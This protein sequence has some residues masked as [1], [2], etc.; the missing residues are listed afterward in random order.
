MLI[1]TVSKSAK[2]NNVLNS[3]VNRTTFEGKT[4]D[5]GRIVKNFKN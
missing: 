1:G 5:E 3:M 2:G 4:E